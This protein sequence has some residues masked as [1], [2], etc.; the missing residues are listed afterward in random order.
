VAGE[1]D[2]LDLMT[3]YEVHYAPVHRPFQGS[4]RFEQEY[5]CFPSSFLGRDDID[6]GNKIILP[7]SA[8]ET[9]ARLN[10]SYP[11]L[12]ELTNE[13]DKR[14]TH[15]GVLEFVAEE[16]TCYLPYWL[17]GHL[18]L[19]EGDI[20]R[21]TNTSLPK[22]T[23]VKLQPVSKEFL[24]VHNPRAVLE[25]SL[26]HFATLTKG[27]NIVI[28]YNKKKFEIEIIETKPS[29]AVSIIEA[30]IEVDFAPPKD[31]VEPVKPSVAEAVR[32]A[33]SD[34]AQA[35]PGGGLA[36]FAGTGN[37]LDGKPVKKT[38]D[39]PL[40]RKLDSASVPAKTVVSA[41]GSIEVKAVEQRNADEPWRNRV[42]GGTKRDPP[43]GFLHLM[44]EH[45][46]R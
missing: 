1:G 10:I 20:V 7:S 17:M 40:L 12:F 41:S 14:M 9:L 27:D 30:D 8:L 31:Y 43:Y 24:E 39:H 28:G 23:F 42:P 32:P 34:E 19:G 4:G 3:M 45:K 33:Q 26:R 13:R 38:G 16:G 29:D 25:N 5:N 11:M 36:V 6:K 46:K 21:V 2:S 15:C 18:L 35:I 22:G 37:R 44:E